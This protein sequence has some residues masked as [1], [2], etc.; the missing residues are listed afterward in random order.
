MCGEH[1]LFVNVF[2]VNIGCL[3]KCV[4]G[5]HHLFVK[6]CMVNIRYMR[7]DLGRLQIRCVNAGQGCE[8]VCPL[9]TLHTH[10]EECEFAYMACRNTGTG[11]HSH[12]L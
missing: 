4:C 1:R 9:E 12:L 8:T 7:N 11:L 3:L 2:V 5:E 6:M 10:E